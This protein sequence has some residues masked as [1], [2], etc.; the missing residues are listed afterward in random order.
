M[1]IVERFIDTQRELAESRGRRF[2]V[3]KPPRS[4]PP[5]EVERDYRAFLLRVVAGIREAV[6]DILVP[7]IPGLVREAGER[8]DGST[9]QRSDVQRLDVRRYNLADIEAALTAMGEDITLQ[10]NNVYLR[11][12]TETVEQYK[13]ATSL[14]V[15]KQLQRQIRTM[16]GLDA[17][18]AV[19]T[20]EA[21][22]LRSWVEANRKTIKLMTTN[23][24]ERVEGLVRRNVQAGYRASAIEREVR[25]QWPKVENRAK[26]IA[27]DQVN[28][29]NGNLTRTRQTSL[30]IKQYIWRTSLDERVRDS[31]L[32]KEGRVF[33]W[34]EPPADTGHP[35]QDIQC[36]CT[37]EPYLPGEPKQSAA[38][39]KAVR[40]EVI[41]S[42]ER[43]AKQLKAWGRTKRGRPRKRR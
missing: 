30:G 27:R 14:K 37:A 7:N 40:E 42:R 28:K 11:Q 33:K 9:V 6:E 23:E 5:D 8:S 12:L 22:I 43:L 25:E 38:E 24:V 19:G 34:S 13:A 36:R 4:Q 17:F 10:V 32:A 15:Q 18:P 3:R 35:G 21:G 20:A 26:L 1:S 29:L 41:A 16:I 31:H 2:R 39:R